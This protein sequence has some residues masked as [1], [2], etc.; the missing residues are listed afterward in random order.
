[1]TSCSCV[2]VVAEQTLRDEL[3]AAVRLNGYEVLSCQTPLEAIQLLERHS[4]RIGYAVLSPAAPRVLEL[5]E[6]LA[7]EYPA[8]Q[9]MVLSS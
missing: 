9:R 4:S 7:D 3:S 8:I 6:L 5:R 1:M 2:L